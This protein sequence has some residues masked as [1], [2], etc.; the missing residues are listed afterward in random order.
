MH[1]IQELILLTL[2]TNFLIPTQLATLITR[3]SLL[4][5]GADMASLECIMHAILMQSSPSMDNPITI[6][7]P[8]VEFLNRDPFTWKF[9]KLTEKEMDEKDFS[10]LDAFLN[11][12]Q[13]QHMNSLL[14]SSSESTDSNDSI[15]SCDEL[16]D[17]DF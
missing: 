4:P 2:L 16:L 12:I 17:S 6:H 8:R 5:T 15:L 13:L 3:L 7:T 9:S 11:P 1:L 14:D 10:F